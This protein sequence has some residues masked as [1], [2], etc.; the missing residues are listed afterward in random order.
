M[1]KM[2][3]WHTASDWQ[4]VSGLAATVDKLC[5]QWLRH[6]DFIWSQTLGISLI[7]DQLL[8]SLMIPFF[9]IE[10][11]HMVFTIDVIHLLP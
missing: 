3:R 2:Q 8:Q 7:P 6:S 1:E 4:R 10:Y 5:L 9:Q 11:K